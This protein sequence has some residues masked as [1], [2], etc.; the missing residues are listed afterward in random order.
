MGLL[1]V[2][3]NDF[4]ESRSLQEDVFSLF[5]EQ[6]QVHV[7]KLIISFTTKEGVIPS[8]S[9]FYNKIRSMRRSGELE[10]ISLKYRVKN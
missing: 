10:D 4:L 3:Y 2:T 6:R 5:D 7:H 8:K 9:M 1:I